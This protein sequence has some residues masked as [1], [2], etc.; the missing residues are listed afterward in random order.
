MYLPYA[1]NE[2]RGRIVFYPVTAK[3]I[4]D[5]IGFLKPNKQMPKSLMNEMKREKQDLLAVITL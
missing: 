5:R 3:I 2:E 4:N 1:L